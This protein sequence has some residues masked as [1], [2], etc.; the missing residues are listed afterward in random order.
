LAGFGWLKR[1]INVG[2]GN[3][4]VLLGG[5]AIMLLVCM[6]PSLITLPMQLSMRQGGAAPDPRTFGLIMGLSMLAGLLVLPLYAGYLQVIDASERGLPARA[7]DVF[8]P[9]RQ[10]DAP[11]LIGYGLAIM[12]VYVGL[13]G[14]VIAATGGGLA[15]WYM[16]ILTA[17]AEHL[18]PPTAL[19]DNF[20]TAI[21]LCMMAGLFM[22]GVYAISLGQVAL[23]RRGVF[24]AIG[25][26]LAGALK[27]LL[28][29]LVFVVSLVLAS[30]VAVIAMVLLAGLLTLLGKLVGTWLV[31]VLVVPLYIAFMVMM[32]AALFGVM[33]HLWRDVC[34][35]DTAPAVDQSLAA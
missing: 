10:G 24:G 13:F 29:L 25:D 33:Y 4:K 20:G 31:L 7:R 5:A 12:V 35:D 30:I 14:A 19:P 27:N 26:G 16:Q 2:H 28:P 6:L 11:R 1:G 3:P 32:V 21:A 23:R 8:A 18:P 22:M 34:G 15:R 17:Q 9:Y